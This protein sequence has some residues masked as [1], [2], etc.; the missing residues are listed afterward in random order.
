MMNRHQHQ[1]HLV[2]ALE[3]AMATNAPIRVPPGSELYIKWFFDLAQT[4]T[5][6]MAGPNPITYAE[7]EAY[8]RLHRWPVG[9]Q[10]ID[11]MVALDQA[12]LAHVR[13][14]QGRGQASGQKV[15]PATFDAVFG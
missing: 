15:S 5:G 8:F 10:H 12:W 4:R 13:A 2:A 11:L 9:A 14:K 3:K 6:G 7:M 1:A